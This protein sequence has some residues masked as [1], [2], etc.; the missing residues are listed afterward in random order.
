MLGTAKVNDPVFVL[1]SVL[2][3]SVR[4]GARFSVNVTWVLAGIDEEVVNAT[5][6]IPPTVHVDPAL[7]REMEMLAGA[8]LQQGCVDAPKSLEVQ[9]LVA[10]VPVSSLT[11]PTLHVNVPAAAPQ[12]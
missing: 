1:V 7:G 8:A 5:L 3:S 12:L 6:S 4:P 11:A 9:G 2:P 10:H